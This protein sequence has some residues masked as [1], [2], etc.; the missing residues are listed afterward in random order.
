MRTFNY[1]E[2]QDAR[3][4]CPVLQYRSPLQPIATTPRI[5]AMTFKF[6]L[7]GIYANFAH[8]GRLDHPVA[9][10]R[11]EGVSII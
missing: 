7:T 4:S 10:T 6:Q 1:K 9:E 2:K 3:E 11:T 8:L 5:Q